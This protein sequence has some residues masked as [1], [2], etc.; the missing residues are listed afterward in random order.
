TWRQRPDPAPARPE[1]PHGTPCAHTPAYPPDPSHHRPAPATDPSTHWRPAPDPAHPAPDPTPQESRPAPA[2]T[3]RHTPPTPHQQPHTAHAPYGSR[4][5]CPPWHPSTHPPPWTRSEE[6][7]VGKEWRSRWAR[8][9]EK[10][11]KKNREDKDGQHNQTQQL[12]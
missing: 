9:H 8:H 2:P 5:R 1:H 4:R 7:R 10:N 12:Q 6:R 3:P 11:K